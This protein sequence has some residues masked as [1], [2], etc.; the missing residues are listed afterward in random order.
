MVDC[1]SAYVVRHYFHFLM[2]YTMKFLVAFLVAVAA[3]SVMATEADERRIE[4][5]RD[6]FRSFSSGSREL[7]EDQHFLFS[8]EEPVRPWELDE[9]KNQYG[10]SV[11]AIH[12]C[13]MR[14]VLAIFVQ[15]TD[16]IVE[17]ASSVNLSEAIARFVLLCR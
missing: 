14:G 9:I 17:R 10:M 12:F 11:Q 3:W 15:P 16:S 7:K 2:T 1:S 4:K 13:T 5:A 6:T 8:L